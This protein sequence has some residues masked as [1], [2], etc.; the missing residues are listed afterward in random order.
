LGKSLIKHT[1]RCDRTENESK[2][3]LNVMKRRE[4]VRRVIWSAWQF[5]RHFTLM[6]L[7]Y[8]L[9]LK[10]FGTMMS[11]LFTKFRQSAKRD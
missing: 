4:Y 9:K 1:L 11:K 10:T 8:T 2:H 3:V 6:E 7:A 5:I